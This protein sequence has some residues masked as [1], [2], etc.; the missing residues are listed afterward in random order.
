MVC[1]ALMTRYRENRHSIADG[2]FRLYGINLPTG[3][4]LFLDDS[5]DQVGKLVGG[6][7]I[8]VTR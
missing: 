1:P 6:H 2:A 3:L 5:Y 8:A 7:H 4:D